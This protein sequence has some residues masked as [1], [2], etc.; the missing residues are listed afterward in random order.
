MNRAKDTLLEEL[1]R[2]ELQ[3]HERMEASGEI[4]FPLDKPP[5]VWLR[6]HDP[7]RTAIDW[8]IG[9]INRARR[10]VGQERAKFASRSEILERLSFERC[11][12]AI[13]DLPSFRKLRT[14]TAPL[15]SESEATPEA[16]SEPPAQPSNVAT[17]RSE[18]EPTRQPESEQASPTG[19]FNNRMQLE[20]H[21]EFLELLGEIASSG[22]TQRFIEHMHI[23]HPTEGFAANGAVGSDPPPPDP[24]PPD[25]RPPDPPPSDPPPPAFQQTTKK[26]KR[27][28][29]RGEARIK[30]IAALTK[31]HKYA[32]DC[33]LNLEP[34]GN[35]ELARQVGVDQATASA[36]FKSQF[37]S[38]VKYRAMCSDAAK[39]TA[40]LKLLNGEFAPHLLYGARPPDEGDRDEE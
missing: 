35:N 29:V 25:P 5:K 37:S 8:L 12:R 40:S 30:L 1:L 32:D 16:A 10:L 36:F 19:T 23:L 39:L 13:R 33:C 22:G 7:L 18:S 26:P 15:Q 31:H 20:D 3:H 2:L 21:R 9:E 24:P 14:A 11:V 6:A 28:T 34:V 27:S 17:P 38:H 4:G